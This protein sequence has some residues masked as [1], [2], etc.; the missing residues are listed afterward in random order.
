MTLDAAPGGYVLD[1]GDGEALRT[2]PPSDLP[3]KCADALV[4]AARV[5]GLEIFGPTIEH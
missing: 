2:F 1:R 3:A 4:E 5:H